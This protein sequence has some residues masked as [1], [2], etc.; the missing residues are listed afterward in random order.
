MSQQCALEAEKANGIQV[1]IR[2]SIASRLKEAILPLRSALVKPQLEYCVHCWASQYKRDRD[3]LERVQLREL[4][5]FS[6]E[7]R[8]LRR[9]FIEV[10]TRR[11]GEKKM[12]PGSFHN[13]T[14][15]NGHKL[16]H[17]RVP[18]NIRKHFF[19]VR[20]TDHW[21]RLPREVVESPS[22]EILKSSLDTVLDNGSSNQQQQQ[23]IH[24]NPSADL[25]EEG[26][27]TP[28]RRLEQI[29]TH[30][31]PAASSSEHPDCY[32]IPKR[33]ERSLAMALAISLSIF[34][35]IPPGPME[36][37]LSAFQRETKFL[38]APAAALSPCMHR[39]LPDCTESTKEKE[40]TG[41]ST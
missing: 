22:L 25:L 19:T 40:E 28:G 13:R 31:P 39:S 17:R 7:K 26:W 8:R 24:N 30:S 37:Y 27:G 12:E 41:S 6:L 29:A 20:V 35:C 1:C 2:Q 10:Y 36:L 21:H 5:L 11:G 16:K 18:L 3:I 23:K 38:P 34:E 15:G 32:D 9:D 4:G 14:R 33:S